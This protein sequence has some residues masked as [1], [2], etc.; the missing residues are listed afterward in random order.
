MVKVK[1]ICQYCNKEFE[2]AD[3]RIRDG[4]GKFCSK[5]CYNESMKN[6]SPKN[7]IGL[8][9][10][11]LIC[12]KTF[13]TIPSRIKEDRGKYCSKECYYISKKGKPSPKWSRV[14]IICQVCGKE[15]FVNKARS[16]QAKYCSN[17][18]R[19]NQV[20]IICIGCSK[21]FFV[22]KA[23]AKKAKYCSRKCCSNDKTDKPS[24]NKGK[25]W[26]NEHKKKLSK[27]HLK[28]IS[29]LT[30]MQNIACSK[31]GKCL[32][33]EYI[34]T[35][36]KLQFLCSEGHKFENQP[37]HILKGQWCPICSAGVSERLCREYFE[38]IFGYKFPKI[39]PKWLIGLKGHRL[40]LDGYCKELNLA[41]EYQ[42][43]QHFNKNEFFHKKRSFDE[44]KKNDEI[45]RKICKAKGI[46]LVEIPDLKDKDRMDSLVVQ[47]CMKKGIDI[48]SA[49]FN[50]NDFD[51]SSPK[52]LKKIK[53]LA[54]SKGGKCLSKRYINV[55]TR[56]RFKCKNGHEWETSP[57][58]IKSGSWCPYCAGTVKGTI[59]EMQRIA[60]SREG[61]CISSEYINNQTHLMWE[62]NEGHR[63]KATP[64]NIK[65]GKW[66][67]KCSAKRAWEKR[68]ASMK[69]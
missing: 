16:K 26:S 37:A 8:E 10:K 7:K 18:C 32:S 33:K 53:D 68:R 39:R 38:H 15:F 27:V 19:S 31:G 59:E 11:C 14:K 62:C 57:A 58:S 66:C 2:T 43:R 5:S 4:K 28:G 36:T 22:N 9:V 21:E 12:G 52:K 44:Q 65:R 3:Y 56:L 55:S 23:R 29:G 50:P 45:K 67:P 13:N 24:W 48:P 51:V 1:R 20:K 63:W 42:G 41:F 34:N 30:L 46:T 49:E 61:K 25:S 6:R 47:E 60:T 17:K 69:Q 64:S 35:H 54:I 40:E